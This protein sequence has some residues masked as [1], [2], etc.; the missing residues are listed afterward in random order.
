MINFCLGFV[1]RKQ[2]STNFLSLRCLRRDVNL[3]FTLLWF[4]FSSFFACQNRKPICIYRFKILDLLLCSIAQTLK[5][6]NA[7]MHHHGC[8]FCDSMKWMMRLSWKYWS[9]TQSGVINSPRNL[10]KYEDRCL[11]NHFRSNISKSSS[12]HCSEFEGGSWVE[13]RIISIYFVLV[14]WNIYHVM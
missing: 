13:I 3:I 10:K 12:K 5:T 4:H 7:L 6:L 2:F 8:L 9:E 14:I 1:R 11:W